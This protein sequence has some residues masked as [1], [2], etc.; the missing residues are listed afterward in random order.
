MGQEKFGAPAQIRG[1]GKK[2]QDGSVNGIKIEGERGNHDDDFNADQKIG[3]NRPGYQQIS[4][5]SFSHLA[6]VFWRGFVW[7]LNYPAL[8]P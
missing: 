6:P 8:F 2:I 1:R 4:V 3:K 7:C 5:S